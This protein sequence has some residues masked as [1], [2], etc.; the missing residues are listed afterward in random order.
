MFAEKLCALFNRNRGRDIYDTLFML[1]KKFPVNTAVLAANKVKG[2]PRELI[3]N[4][5]KGLSKK[6]L[7]FL[8]NQIRPF[9]FK[10]DDAELVLNS[11]AYAERFLRE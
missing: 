6:E 7:I 8:A 1:K 9:L 5:L 3:L 11:T 2:E 4:H 10:E